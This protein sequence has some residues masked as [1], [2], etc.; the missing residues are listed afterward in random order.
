[1]LINLT[2]FE[3]YEREKWAYKR[4]RLSILTEMGKIDKIG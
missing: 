3:N 1:M 4:Y 2:V